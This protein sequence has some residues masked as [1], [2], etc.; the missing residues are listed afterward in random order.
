M[1]YLVAFFLPFISIFACEKPWQGLLNM[2]LWLCAFLFPPLFIVCVVH[3]FVV[4]ASKK[5]DERTDRLI[6]AMKENPK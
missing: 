4:V 1:L 2:L 3:A 5:S 6:Q